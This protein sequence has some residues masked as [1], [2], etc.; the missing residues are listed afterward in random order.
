M[1]TVLWTSSVK[2]Q[3]YIRISRWRLIVKILDVW[4]LNQ[5]GNCLQVSHRQEAKQMGTL[6]WCIRL[7]GLGSCL[8]VIASKNN[9]DEYLVLV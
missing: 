5:F 6:Y 1:D 7:R 3:S 9:D 8:Q 2:K 4:Y